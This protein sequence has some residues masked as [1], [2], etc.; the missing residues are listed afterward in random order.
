MNIE[1]RMPDTLGIPGRW[2]WGAWTQIRP[3]EN[4]RSMWHAKDMRVD[5][6]VQKCMRSVSVPM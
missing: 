5:S 6:Q 2:L 4:P 3:P 1:A